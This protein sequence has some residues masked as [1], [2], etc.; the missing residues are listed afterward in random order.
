MITKEH[1]APVKLALDENFASPA[2]VVRAIEHAVQQG[3]QGWGVKPEVAVHLTL[4]RALSKAL[5]VAEDADKDHRTLKGLQLENGRLK[6]QLSNT[7][8]ALAR[9]KGELMAYSIRVRE[10]EE[11]AN[12]LEAELKTV[13][14]GLDED[15]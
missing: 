6:K 5:D 7:E 2:E 8:E 4:A 9:Q 14:E 3:S 13:S 15:D 10:L 1:L 12:K 11:I